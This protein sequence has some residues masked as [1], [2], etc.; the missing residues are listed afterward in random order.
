MAEMKRLI[1]TTRLLTLTGPGGTG[2]T[3]LSLQVAADILDQF[4]HGVW[5]VELSTV[6]DPALIPETIISAVDIREEPNKTPL[7]TLTDALR[8][9]NLLLVLDN[10]EHLIAGCAQIASTLLRHCPQVKIIASSREPLSIEGETL[11]AVSALAVPALDYFAPHIDFDEV[12]NLEAIQLFVERAQAVKNDFALTKENALLVAQICWRL[13][14][15]PLALELAAARVKVLPLAQILS[16]L[17]DRFRLLTG[18]SRT[19]LPRQQTLGAL[20]DWSYDLL[21]EPE[22]ILLRRLAVFVAGRSLEMAESVCAGDGL[23]RSDV[24]DLLCSLVEKSLLMTETGPDGESRYTMLESIWDYADNKLEQHN[25]TAIYR[26]KHLEFFVKFAETA[27]PHLI[28]KDQK[29]W[30]EKLGAEQYNLWFALRN[31][32]LQKETVEL[33]LRLAGAL[34]RYWEVRS[35]LTEGYEQYQGLFAQADES[36][37]VA[38]RAKA[39]LGAARVSWCQDRDEDALR[40]YREAQRLYESLGLKEQVGLI[41]AY[42]GFAE[43]NEG[44]NAIARDHF[45]KARAMGEELKS[46]RIE[47]MALGGFSSVAAAEGN[48]AESRALKEEDIRLYQSMGDRWIVSLVTGSLGKVC[49]ALGDYAAARKYLRE[50]LTIIRDL[51]N[52]WSVPYALEA[53]GDVCAV[54]Q[55]ATKAVC[56]Y[57]AA[58]AQRETL[59]L[60]F[61]PTEKISYQKALDRLHE[62][63]PD[64][65]F[66]EEWKKG[67]EIGFQ[68]AI[69][70]AM[71]SELN[72]TLSG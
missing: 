29:T 31:S 36:I 41:E 10:C 18:G 2:K 25:E 58:R 64:E 22:R 52:K 50:A 63:V 9:R 37:P 38:V 13:D 47:A 35:Y 53:I 21:S 11:W 39:E 20:I 46:K 65:A 6:S 54:E 12:V 16:R 45:E 30:L 8:T 19:A 48:L 55:Q 4:P 66:D 61:S 56:L 71:E 67:Q 17:D 28:G 62:L 23:D 57:G 43:R 5:L 69:N 49:Y 68:G 32:L 1:G 26:R 34:T 15:I 44:N 72:S 14:G 59:A 24:F 42:I 51:G 33:G 40:H 60:A 70:L 3:R 7:Q 27:E